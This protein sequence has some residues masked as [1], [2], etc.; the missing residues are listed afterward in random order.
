[1][2]IHKFGLCVRSFGVFLLLPLAVE[3]GEVHIYRLYNHPAA[4]FTRPDGSAGAAHGARADGFVLNSDA[5]EPF[6]LDF[7]ATESR[8]NLSYFEESSTVEIR[9]IA[10]GGRV[11]DGEFIHDQDYR[12]YDMDVTYKVEPASADDDDL[13]VR[14]PFQFQGMP[15][16]DFRDSNG[17][18]ILSFSPPPS[19]VDGDVIF[20]FGDNDGTG[21]LGHNGTSGWGTFSFHE[22]GSSPGV[23]EWLFSAVPIESSYQFLEVKLDGTFVANGSAQTLGEVPPGEEKTIAIAFWL[24]NNGPVRIEAVEFIGDEQHVFSTDFAGNVEASGGYAGVFNITVAPLNSDPLNVQ[25]RLSGPPLGSSFECSLFVNGP[26]IEPV[27]DG[28]A[29]HPLPADET[30][31]GEGQKY[32]SN[33]DFRRDEPGLGFGGNDIN[34]IVS[35]LM[36]P[37]CGTGS[38]PAMLT[39][40][41][42]L[43]RHRT[44]RARA[45]RPLAR[46]PR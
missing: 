17:D 19:I 41:L 25:L 40:M 10:L 22:L 1:M 7:N 11:I 37:S 14:V 21:H 24:H 27:V 45:S 3:A 9:G 26:V 35:S 8:V 34:E 43:S 12:L 20:Q 39:V 13:V 44:R 15:N 18:H 16:G 5:A 4:R 30:S 23:R 28:V 31:I 29:E 46:R 42:M 32:A 36:D 38:V 2:I 6:A 33:P